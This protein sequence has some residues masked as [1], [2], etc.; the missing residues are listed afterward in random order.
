[1]WP[2][3]LTAVTQSISSSKHNPSHYY[4]EITMRHNCYTDSTD[5]LSNEMSSVNPSDTSFQEMKKSTQSMELEY[6][7]SWKRS[8]FGF[9]FILFNYYGLY[10]YPTFKTTIT[11]L[12]KKTKLT[13]EW[14]GSYQNIEEHYGARR[15]KYEYVVAEK[16]TVVGYRM[17]CELTPEIK[18]FFDKV[19]PVLN[20][21]D[22]KDCKLSSRIR[23][24]IKQLENLMEGNTVVVEPLVIE[25]SS[26]TVS[27]CLATITN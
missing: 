23:G 1:V 13:P 8:W 14:E 12:K 11:Y 9:N 26:W 7:D 15:I 19:I 21:K 10:P 22:K 17:A 27:W 20:T 24:S 4:S 25:G 2:H 18:V 5:T 16:E 3:I 6:Y